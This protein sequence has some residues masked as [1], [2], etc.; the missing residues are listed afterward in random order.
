[1]QL[2]LVLWR[3]RWY[4]WFV[5]ISVLVLRSICRW[6]LSPYNS[7]TTFNLDRFS[8]GAG[9]FPLPCGLFCFIAVRFLEAAYWSLEHDGKRVSELV[10]ESI[11][12][13]ETVG[14]HRIRKEDV[15]AVGVK[16][17]ILVKGVDLRR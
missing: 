11:A 16:G 4:C 10:E 17:T 13:R 7:S 15:A 12:W 8:A 14:A 3:G 2:V 5:F 9:T 6:P 1:M